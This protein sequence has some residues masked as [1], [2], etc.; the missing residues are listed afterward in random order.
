VHVICREVK[1]LLNDQLTT[2]IIQQAS[3]RTKLL[4]EC[5]GQLQLMNLSKNSH[6]FVH[7]AH[8]NP[9]TLCV[10]WTPETICS[11]QAHVGYT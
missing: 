4:L 10:T 3:A 11:A 1:W 6:L 9:E 8:A 2:P 7:Q 5:D